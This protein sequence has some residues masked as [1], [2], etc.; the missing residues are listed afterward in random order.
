MKFKSAL[1]SIVLTGLA[2]GAAQAQISI[3][4]GVLTD[5]SGAYSDIG[6]EGSAVAARMAVEDFIAKSS[7]K[8]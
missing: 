5:R 3:K 4:L 7:N 1:L 2:A 6:G 8:N